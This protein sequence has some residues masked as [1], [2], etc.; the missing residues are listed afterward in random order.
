MSLIGTLDAGQVRACRR[1]VGASYFGGNDDLLAIYNV[2]VKVAAEGTS[3]EAVWQ[4]VFGADKPYND[5]RFRKFSSDLFKLVREFLIQQTL[6]DQP[7]LQEYLYLTALEKRPPEKLLR[8]VERGL[9]TAGAAEESEQ[10]DPQA[11]LQRHLLE[12]RKYSLLNFD[13]RPFD[14][15]NM[16]RVSS[17]LDRYFIVT[18]IINATHAQSRF[19]TEQQKY[20]LKLIPEVVRFLDNDPTYLLSEPLVAM[21]YYMYKMLTA[22]ED[23]D[24]MYERYKQRIVAVGD[25]I[26]SRQGYEF[27]QAALNYCRRRINEGKQAF[28]SEY[29]EVYKYAL[30]H[31]YV[32]DNGQLDPLQFRNTILTALRLGEYDWAERYITDYQHKLPVAQRVNAVNYN[33]ATLYFYQKN[34]DQALE[35]L[36]DVEYE[37][38]TYNLN[39]KTMLLAIY[40]ETQA[41]DALDSLFDAITT[42]LHRHKELPQT[43][44]EA[45]G[46][47]VNFTLRLTRILPGDER[48]LELLKRDV[49]GVKYV[50]SRPW[51][52]DKILE[53]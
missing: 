27:F 41:F 46:N 23:D 53:L 42:Y 33:S 38:T 39:A 28:L 34:Y 35:F 26:G 2:L 40:Y 31:G 13:H 14:H 43:A 52:M 50:A 6:A 7:K 11:F 24:T 51:L 20:D 3:K 18:K 9:Q 30:R 10:Y 4:Q 25:A 22:E 19:Q 37:N 8:G 49:E 21:H 36:R 32:F 16:E 1:L 15:S 47:L 48:A 44:R 12:Q 45:F 17:E 5:V 29:L